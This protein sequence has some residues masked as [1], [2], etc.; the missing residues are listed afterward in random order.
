MS[1]SFD[2]IPFTHL[3]DLVEGRLA[4]G[5]RALVEAHVAACP[6]CAADVAWLERVIGLMRTDD[7]E[8]PPRHILA[9]VRRMFRAPA[10]PA[11]A[12]P[13]RRIA[14]ALQVDSARGPLAFGIR[15]GAAAE[16]QMLF[17]AAE[18]DLDL[19]VA[20]SGS[21]WQV[22]GQVL[23]TDDEQQAPLQTIELHGPAGAVR[24]TLNSLSEFT[25]PPTPAGSYTLT[26]HLADIDIAIAE[27]E[28]GV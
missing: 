25:L 16:R 22:S 17:T 24:A 5:E 11:A 4:R 15:T 1:I 26:L 8:A 13:R 18:Y 19:R 6:R 3:V 20:P 9:Q 27:L 2:H 21:L 28:I 7:S 23:G 12:T 14:A 10:E